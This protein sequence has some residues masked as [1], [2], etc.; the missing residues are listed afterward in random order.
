MR[1]EIIS[2]GYA[3][4]SSNV[5]CARTINFIPE[6]NGPDGKS[7]WTLTGSP[8]SHLFTSLGV[9]VVRGSHVFNGLTYVVVGSGLYSLNMATKA[10]SAS[11][12]T[13]LTTTGRVMM[14]DNG[15]KPTGGNQIIITDGSAHYYLYDVSSSL[16][17]VSSSVLTAPVSGGYSPI[18]WNGTI[19]LTVCQNYAAT[20]A[21]GITWTMH[22]MPIGYSWTSV[23]WNGTVFCALDTAESLSGI[24]IPSTATSSDG[25]TWTLHLGSLPAIAD[26]QYYT[27]VCAKSGGNFFAVTAGSVASIWAAGSADGVTWGL[28]SVYSAQYWNFVMNNGTIFLAVCNGNV[29]NISTDGSTWYEHA[30]PFGNWKSV[31]WNGSVFCAIA[32]N[33][34]ATSPNG[35]TWNSHTLPAAY[36]YTDIV[37]NGICFYTISG[38]RLDGGATSADGITWFKSDLPDTSLWYRLGTNGVGTIVILTDTGNEIANT[39]LN[40]YFDGL[41]FLSYSLASNYAAYTCCYINGYFVIDL[42]A[43][44]WSVSALY[45]G[46]SFP[47]LNQSGSNVTNDN[48]V[49]VISSQ[50]Y[51]LT[52]GNFIS[53]VWYLTGSASPLFALM[54]NGNFDYGCAARYSITKATNTLYWLVNIRN[55]QGGEMIGVMAMSGMAMSPV[56]TPAINYLFGQIAKNYGVSDCWAYS[57]IEDGHEHVRFTFPSDNSGAGSTYDYITDTQIWCE[58]MTYPYSYSSPGRHIANTYFSYGGK[59]YI[60]S[61]ADGSIYEMSSAFYDDFGYGITCTR[62][63]EPWADKDGLLNT[64]IS[65]LQIDMETGM[66]VPTVYQTTTVDLTTPMVGHIYLT[67]GGVSWGYML[68]MTGNVTNDMENLYYLFLTGGGGGNKLSASYIAPNDH[69]QGIIWPYTSSAI[70]INDDNNTNAHKMNS[71]TPNAFISWS[72]DGGHTWS[73]SIIQAISTVANYLARLI[74][75]RIGAAR[76]WAFNFTFP[77]AYKKVIQSAYVDYEKGSK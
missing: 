10:V 23:A 28:A 41:H 71:Y 63:T 26:S 18:I 51:L 53:Q 70:V 9:G 35:I 15:L 54:A 22:S 72:K 58:V 75:W 66:T 36:Q 45:D 7:Q 73:N 8:G 17:K 20:S 49:A 25:V 16:F 37:W 34:C 42:G 19:Y 65:K 11:S 64:F 31:A 74:I 50:G 27:S 40:S 48:V 60:G 39:P 62:I 29:C 69:A 6:N 46:T 24:H 76:Q 68:V 33:A 5:S 61:W 3:G 30:M 12:G 38:T 1:K 55:D 67:V 13:L 52:V 14:S 4:R 47:A 56:S 2:P 57:F 59:H 32:G 77:G 44:Q 21:D 43:G